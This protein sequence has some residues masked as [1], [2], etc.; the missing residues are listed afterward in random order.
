MSSVV[1]ASMNNQILKFSFLKSFASLSTRR[2]YAKDIRSEIGNVTKT[3]D[4]N[5]NDNI[6][7]DKDINDN[8]VKSDSISNSNNIITSN[9]VAETNLHPALK[10]AFTKNIG[11]TLTPVQEQCINEFLNSENGIVVRAKTGTGKTFAFGI[12]VIHSV[13]T[14]KDK[15]IKQVDRYVNSVVFSPTRDLAFQTRKSL[16]ELWNSSLNSS[17]HAPKKRHSYPKRSRLP[18]NEK[19]LIP[20]VIG[21]TPYRSTM[22]YFVSKEIPPIVVAT[23]GR[24]MDMLEN[25][26]KFRTSFKHLQNIIIDEADELLNGNF[27]EDINK[28]IDELNSIRVPIPGIEDENSSIKPKTMLFSATVNDDVFYLAERAIGNDFPFVDVTGNK[29]E[30]VNENITQTLIQTDSIFDTYVAAVQFIL[31]NVHDRNFKPIIFLSTTSSVDFISKLLND[32]LRSENSRRRVLSF[33]GKL[34]QGK[35]DAS[36]RIFREKDNAI[37]VA[38]GIGARGMDFPNVSHVIQIGVSSE[39]DSHTHK[40]GRTG[41]AGKQGDALLF[42]S[43]LEEPFVKALKK[44]GNKFTNVKV[45]DSSEPEAEEVAEK[46]VDQTKS[47]LDLE[48]TFFKSLTHYRNIPSK[49]AKLDLNGLAIDLAKTYQKL[50]SGNNKTDDIENDE[51]DVE[52]ENESSGKITMSYN[53]AKNLGLDFTKVEDYYNLTGRRPSTRSSNDSRGNYRNNNRNSKREG[54]SNDRRGSYNN[55]GSRDNRDN[56]DNRNRSRRNNDYDGDRW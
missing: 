7:I 8:N 37:L 54:W 21:Q 47:Y 50:I 17:I 2:Y 39:I 51:D 26:P 32:V 44:N 1:F 19:D 46:I 41:R 12:P 27:K 55:R 14:S 49:V 6:N 29:T 42:T 30:E 20:L 36:Q 38:S 28:I 34:S 10:T 45:F 48:D 35:R 53:M 18:N 3:L 4:S 31:D 11:P 13:L 52:N 25:E 40:I 24:F 23:P 33:H 16:T 9:V 22:S 5:D 15:N 43:K 56:R